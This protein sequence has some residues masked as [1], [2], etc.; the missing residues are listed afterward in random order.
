MTAVLPVTIAIA[1]WAHIIG[2]ES[3]VQGLE[4]NLLR[5]YFH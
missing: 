1:L 4:N 3:L 5:L 2:K